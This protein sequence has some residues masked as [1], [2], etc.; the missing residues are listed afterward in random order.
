MILWIVILEQKAVS[1]VELLPPRAVKL[2][3]V[4]PVFLR[5]ILQRRLCAVIVE[6]VRLSH[7]TASHAISLPVSS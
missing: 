6:V 4:I 1:E 5:A 7:V 3:V 2:H